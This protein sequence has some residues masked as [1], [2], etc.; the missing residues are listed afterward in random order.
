[1]NT[2][3]ITIRVPNPFGAI[4]ARRSAKA[5]KAARIIE[6]DEHLRQLTERRDA[7]YAKPLPDTNR[8]V[9]W[10]EKVYDLTLERIALVF[11]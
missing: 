6:I 11:G 10:D 9:I 5:A 3:A 2:T 1:M 4:K 7:E 8:I